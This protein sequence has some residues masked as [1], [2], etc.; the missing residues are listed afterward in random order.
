M[1]TSDAQAR[2]FRLGS[3]VL[4]DESDAYVIAEIGANHQGERAIALQL[5]KAA[6]A[7]G[8]DAVKF[9]KRDN[10]RLFTRE[11]Y[12]APY[13]NENSFGATYGEH[14]EALELGADDYRAIQDEAEALGIDFFATAFDLPSVDFLMSLGVPAFKV[15]S[16]DLTNSPLLERIASTNV[17]TILSTGGGTQQSVDTAVQVFTD[18]GTEV[19]VLQCTSGYPPSFEELNLQVIS[20]FRER[21][22]DLVIGFSGHDSGIA[23]AVVA[24]A[25]GGRIVEKHFTLNRAMKGTDHAFSLEPDGLRKM[26]RDLRRARLAMGDGVKRRYDSEIAPHQ[27]LAK[28][29]VA[30][31]D[32]PEG[33]V[34]VESDLDYRSPG[35]GIPPA[36]R[37]LVVGK[38]L[39]K[40]VAEG[41][42]I[43]EEDLAVD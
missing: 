4:S 7:A 38:R 24:F 28:M 29:I 6:A 19:A 11:G 39:L 9:Q 31:R 25:L 36:G 12:V 26:V 42:P 21:Y 27:K 10:K 16:F 8:A 33:T 37:D 32:L 17:P 40:A 43:L 5:V 34:V 3:K 13:V 30:A 35:T 2:S 41:S 1:P 22:P 15:A 20:T 14:R 18:A 23:M